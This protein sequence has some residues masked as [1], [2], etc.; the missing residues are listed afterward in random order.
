MTP[1]DWTPEEYGDAWAPVYDRFHDPKLDTETAVE[2][3]ARLAGEGRV[4][5]FGIGTGRLALPLA[6]RG[7][8]VH[9][10]DASQAMVARLRAKPGGGHIPVVI[11]D[12]AQARAEG[13]FDLVLLAF[14]TLFNLPSQDAQCRCFANAAGHL[15]RRGAFVVEAFVPD[16]RRFH[17]DQSVRAEEIDDQNVVLEVARHDPVN[18]QVVSARVMIDDGVQTRLVKIRYAWPSEIDLMARLAGLGLAERWG[19]WSGEPFTRESPTHISVYRG[20]RR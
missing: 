20:L 1:A 11:G 12:F 10:I 19:G 3:L 14:N 15:T 4:L 16:L 2:A 7:L 9:G 13:R 6:A 17:D 18:Q 8:E 5:E